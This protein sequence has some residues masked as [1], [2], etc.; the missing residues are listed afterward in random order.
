MH[1]NEDILRSALLKSSCQLVEKGLNKGTSGNVSIRTLN[2]FLI[3]PSGIPIEQ[4]TEA[5]MVKVGMDG[6]F[7]EGEN[8]SSEWPFHMAIYTNRDEVEAVVH[9]HSMYATALS[10]LRKHIPPFHYMVAVAGGDDIRCA[11]YALFGSQLLSNYVVKALENR[12]ACLMA[13]HGMVAAASNI[14]K[15]LYIAEEVEALSQQ[16][17]SALQV[18]GPVL[19]TVEEMDAVKAR[20]K[21][22]GALSQ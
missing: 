10:T 15:A 16:Y 3:T 4:L 2:G 9:T 7:D 12:N 8:P 13:N 5:S 19:L 20:F 21:G 14:D 17:L 11:P 22:Y 6:S 1:T 18:G